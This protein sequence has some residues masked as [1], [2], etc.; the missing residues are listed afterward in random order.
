M[1]KQSL[2]FFLCMFFLT[3]AVGVNAL[4]I[5]S[6]WKKIDAGDVDFF[7]EDLF[8]TQ[9]QKVT[10]GQ[11]VLLYDSQKVA[12]ACDYW[13]NGLYLCVSTM[14][15]RVPEAETDRIDQVAVENGT[16]DFLYAMI[17]EQAGTLDIKMVRVTDCA[18]PKT[19]LFVPIATYKK[20]E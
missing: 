12:L 15:E 4:T 10:D 3:Y 14:L 18:D 1:K 9:V 8:V 7:D 13:E 19:C 11:Y 17:K 6:A 20:V 5:P 16:F 2:Y